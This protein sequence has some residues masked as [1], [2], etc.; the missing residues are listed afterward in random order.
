[1]IWAK[2]QFARADY[3]PYQDRLAKLELVNA[4]QQRFYMLGVSP[5]DR[6]KSDYYVGL[7]SPAYL[8]IFDGFEVVSEAEVPHQIDCVLV[9][10]IIADVFQGRFVVRH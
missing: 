1:L 9:G 2:R 4:P 7:P 6:T 3:G 8:A 10:D 5:P